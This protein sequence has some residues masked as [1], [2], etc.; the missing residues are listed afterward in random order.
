M[1]KNKEEAVNEANTMKKRSSKGIRYFKQN[2]GKLDRLRSVVNELPKVEAEKKFDEISAKEFDGLKY[3]SAVSILKEL[4]SDRKHTID[5]TLAH[6]NRL[7]AK[8]KTHNVSVRF[9]DED[10]KKVKKVFSKYP[11][12]SMAVFIEELTM[13]YVQDHDCD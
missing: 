6:L 8:G 4:G 11:N 13:S 12:I 1:S 3:R 9:S 7:G 10:F 5:E 2:P